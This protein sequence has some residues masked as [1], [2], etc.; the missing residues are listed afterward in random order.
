MGRFE[1]KGFQIVGLKMLVPPKTLVEEHYAEHKERPFFSG[2]VD[3]LTSGPVVA[4]AVKGD[5]VVASSRS[6]IGAT[7]PWEAVPGTIRSD[8]AVTVGRNIIH[9][10]DSPESAEREL[11]LWFKEGEI[12]EWN[13]ASKPWVYEE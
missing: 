4:V 13:A 5:N 1:K 12:A 6:M 3:F 10:S 2:L 11:G 8:L 9:G 7:K